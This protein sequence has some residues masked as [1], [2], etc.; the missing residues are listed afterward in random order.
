MVKYQEIARR[1]RES[2][3]SGEVKPGEQLALER[4]MCERYGVSRITIKKAVD[5]LVADGLVVKRRGSGTFVKKLAE[6]DVRDVSMANQFGGFTQAFDGHAVTTEVERFE[7]IHPSEEVAEKLHLTTDDFVYDIVR[8]RK[9]DEMPF[10]IEYTHMPV[11]LFPGLKRDV[12]EQS[13]YRYIEETLHL[14]IQSAHRFIRAL[15]PTEEEE[16]L[17]EI[18]HGTLPLLEVE[19]VAFLDDT[20]PFEFSRSHH[21]GDCQT[22]RVVSIR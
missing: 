6:S 7:I 15:L 20:R 3:Q 21:R 2:I 14:K 11:E 18:E 5:E 1:L 13:I 4:E 8:L 19:Q 22:F 16:A 10:V 17:L 12:L 9:V